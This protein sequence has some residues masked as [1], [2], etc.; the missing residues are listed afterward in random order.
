MKTRPPKPQPGRLLEM[1]S[2]YRVPPAQ[3]PD[4]ITG[5][6]ERYWNHYAPILAACGHLDQVC[7]SMFAVLC[8]TWA[9]LVEVQAIIAREGYTIQTRNGPRAH[10]LFAEEMRT[11][12]LFL[13]LSRAFYMTPASRAR[14]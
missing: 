8:T 9:R 11:M 4:W 3:K 12:R 1:P 14:K 13:S 6:A 7:E 5:E 10:P 2:A